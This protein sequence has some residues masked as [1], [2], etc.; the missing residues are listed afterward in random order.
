MYLQ[1]TDYHTAYFWIKARILWPFSS[2][3]LF[4]F[5]LIYIEKE[6][7]LK[8]KLVYFLVY[9]PTLI[10]F[11]IFT[12]FS[13]LIIGKPVNKS[14][15]ALLGYKEGDP[16]YVP[17]KSIEREAIR[18]KKLVEDL[19]AFSRAGKIEREKVDINGT[20][21]SESETGK[22]TKFKIKLSKG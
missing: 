7:W 18:C 20:I 16:L 14:L 1:T 8:H 19:L 21:E 6:K 12:L 15:L 4:C 3:L 22:G 13:H 10:L 9:F 5:T 11:I 2:C 17:L